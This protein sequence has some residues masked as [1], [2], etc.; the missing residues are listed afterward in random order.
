[1]SH[2]SI[3]FLFV[4]FTAAAFLY[5]V[6]IGCA[7]PPSGDSS[8]TVT[9]DG[10]G[11]TGGSV[12]EDS[13]S[14]YQEGD[15][16]TVLGN[17]GS[18]TLTGFTFDGWNTEA[19]GGGTAYAPDDEFEMPPENLVLYAQWEEIP[20][21]AYLSG[22]LSYV[23]ELLSEGGFEPCADSGFESAQSYSTAFNSNVSTGYVTVLS[24]GTVYVCPVNED[25]SFGTCVTS[26]VSF[27]GLGPVGVALNPA[28][29]R[30]YVTNVV[31]STVS[32]CTIQ[33]NG[34]FSG[35]VD[36]GVVSPPFD[37]PEGIA[38]NAA[39]TIAYVVNNMGNSISLCPI[40]SSTGTFNST[41]TSF[42]SASFPFSNPNMITLNAAGTFAYIPNEAN[43]VSVCPIQADGSLGTCVDSGGS[44]VIDFDQPA[45]VAFNLPGTI[46]YVTNEGGLGSVYACPVLSN[47]TFDTCTMVEMADGLILSNLWGITIVP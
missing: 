25:H 45:Q 20:S 28:N 24:P 17:T 32:V 4:Y 42:T 22:G 33:S 14:P 3:R 37:S 12:P 21:F 35:C 11:S 38:I 23:C 31:A 46:A 36:S 27:T 9:Y 15:V 2:K 26:G 10:N 18:L 39:G 6:G 19:D 7:P 8:Y 16:V 13:G 29:T 43:F 30:A 1:M 40:N 44:S 5:L 34:T 47:G 41:C